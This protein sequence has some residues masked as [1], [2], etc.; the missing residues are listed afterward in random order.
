MDRLQLPDDRRHACRNCGSEKREYLTTCMACESD[1]CSD[2]LVTERDM[3]NTSDVELCRDCATKELN[4]QLEVLVPACS[5]EEWP[6]WVR[7]GQQLRITEAAYQL[8]E[9]V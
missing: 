4:A 8:Q 5:C 2:C 6:P 9:G 7:Y 3:W 1:I